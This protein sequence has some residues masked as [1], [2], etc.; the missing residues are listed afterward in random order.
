MAKSEYGWMVW[1]ASAASTPDSELVTSVGVWQFA[2]PML[3]NSV[4]PLAIEAAD[5]FPGIPVLEGAGGVE[6]R[7]ARAKFVMSE[8]TSDTVP[9]PAGF[10][11]SSGVPL[12]LKQAA[13]FP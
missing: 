10:V 1:L 11:A 8:P 6:S 13:R 9:V 3:V 2:H 4:S 7:M 12:M 5:G